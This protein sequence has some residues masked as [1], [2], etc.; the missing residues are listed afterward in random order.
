MNIQIVIQVNDKILFSTIVFPVVFNTKLT[1]SGGQT[2]WYTALERKF[3]F[4]LRG[5]I[6]LC[7]LA[8]RERTGVGFSLRR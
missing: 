2:A 8:L 3:L 6:K 1:P 4:S 7:N 5:K